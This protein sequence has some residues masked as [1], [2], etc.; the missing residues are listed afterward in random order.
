MKPIALRWPYFLPRLATSPDV[1]LMFKID[2]TAAASDSSAICVAA[3]VTRACGH[4]YPG[5]GAGKAASNAPFS[6]VF[7]HLPAC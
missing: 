2:P 7:G 6:R 1:L 3:V 5:S 4:W